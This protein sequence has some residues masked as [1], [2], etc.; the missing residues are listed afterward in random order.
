VKSLVRAV[1]GGRNQTPVP[2]RLARRQLSLGQ[3]SRGQALTEFA[4]VLPV[5]LLLMLIAVDFGR[6]LF[7]YIAVNNAAREATYHAGVHGA[8][9]PFNQTAYVEAVRAV[10]ER[11]AN[12]QGQGG[13][14]VLTVS[15]P[16]CSMAD[17]AILD[18]HAA[19]DFGTGTRNRVTVSVSQPFDFLTP[20]IGDLFGGGVTLTASA[21]GPVFSPPNP[22]IIENPD[23]P[24][25]PPAC[26][27]AAFEWEVPDPTDEPLIVQFTDTSTGDPSTWAWDF[28]DESSNDNSS[29]DRN[30]VHEYSADGNYTV[31]LTVNAGD[32]CP[33][34]SPVIITVG[35]AVPPDP[36]PAPT[37]CVVPNF[38]GQWWDNVGGVSAETVWEA[39]FFTGKLQNSAGPN[40]ITG[41]TLPAISSV[42]C[43]S[44]MRVTQN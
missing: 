33:A 16:V 21:T 28:G 36:D 10:G 14:G 26:P 24:P 17:G 41:Q 13:E 3:K 20:F 15:A 9:T 27:Q 30:P 11:E 6:L 18:C 23:P 35:D 42:A 5:M 8:D 44:N 43:T 7:T 19:S 25:P 31:T 22:T 32:G 39:A 12:V 34:G 40:Q 29:A 38:V 37:T 4:L 2:A 1:R